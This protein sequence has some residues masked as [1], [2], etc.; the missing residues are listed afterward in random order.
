MEK[1]SDS[2][3][4]RRRRVVWGGFRIVRRLCLPGGRLWKTTTSYKLLQLTQAHHLWHT[5]KALHCGPTPHF[6]LLALMVEELSGRGTIEVCEGMARQT[7]LLPVWDVV[8][9]VRRH[10]S[11]ISVVE[12][13]DHFPV[14]FLPTLTN[15]MFLH[16]SQRLLVWSPLV[17]WKDWRR[18]H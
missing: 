16:P 13:C 7:H 9:H 1:L 3:N 2:H 5:W 14:R 6:L 4:L 17:G 12:V 8:V 10:E 15:L 18:S 11:W